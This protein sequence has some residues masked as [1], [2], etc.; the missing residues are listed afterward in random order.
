MRGDFMKKIISI[1][2]TSIM[3][4]TL[5][6]GCTK[7]TKSEDIEIVFT[8]TIQKLDDYGHTS[9][10]LLSDSEINQYKL[11]FLEINKEVKGMTSKDK[12]LNDKICLSVMISDLMCKYLDGVSVTL[13]KSNI[14]V[15]I[16]NMYFL[17]FLLQ[18]AYIASRSVGNN[19][20]ED[21]DVIDIAK[22]LNY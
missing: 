11:D 15:E 10:L 16:D 1:L 21:I 3:L 8:K 20:R 17:S 4:L 14:P 9:L 5:L 22:E 19:W 7:E 18:R 13:D 12:D 6:T 2:L